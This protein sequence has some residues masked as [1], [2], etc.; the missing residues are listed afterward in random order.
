MT[1]IVLGDFIEDASVAASVECAR[2][3][4]TVDDREGRSVAG[5]GDVSDRDVDLG[6]L[7]AGECRDS[8]DEQVPEGLRYPRD[9]G[10]PA[11]HQPNRDAEPG[12]VRRIVRDWLGRG[13]HDPRHPACETLRDLGNGEVD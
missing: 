2:H 3:R 9:R 1:V 5:L 10:A 4:S 11:D 7:G 8:S 6:Q 12:G 13:E